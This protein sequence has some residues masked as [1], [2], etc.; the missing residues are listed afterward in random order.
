MEKTQYGLSKHREAGH[1][2]SKQREEAKPV[3]RPSAKRQPRV[4]EPGVE[5]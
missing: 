2:K 3:A 4:P 1:N 5:S